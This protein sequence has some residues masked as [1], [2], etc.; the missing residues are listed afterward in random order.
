MKNRYRE[1]IGAVL[2]L[3]FVSASLAQTGAI[4]TTPSGFLQLVD[5]G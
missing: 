5:G 2:T 1:T 3:A 4:G